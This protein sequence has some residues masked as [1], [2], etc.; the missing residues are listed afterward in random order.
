M[1]RLWEALCA[2]ALQMCVVWVLPAVLGARPREEEELVQ[3]PVA[4][5][6]GRVADC[7]PL[8]QH[9]SCVGGPD[10]VL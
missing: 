6:G 9:T 7:Q 10:A 5:R 4:L 3:V 8:S 1:D 2:Q